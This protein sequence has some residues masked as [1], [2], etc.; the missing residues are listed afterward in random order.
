VLTLN[1]FELSVEDDN[2]FKQPTA[3]YSELD[4]SIVLIGDSE[5]ISFGEDVITVRFADLTVSGD[6]TLLL[7]AERIDVNGGY[8]YGD[9]IDLTFG[10][11]TVNGGM[12]DI[13]GS[14]HGIEIDYGNLTVNGGEIYI[15]AEDEGIDITGGDLTLNDGSIDI[16]ADDKGIDIGGN[17]TVNG[18][19]AEIFSDDDGIEVSE[20]LRITDGKIDVHSESIGIEVSGEVTIIGAEVEISALSEGLLAYGNVTLGGIFEISAELGGVVSFGDIL[21]GNV[22]FAIETDD[23]MYAIKAAAIT[24]EGEQ[25][26]VEI[27]QDSDAEGSYS[28]IDG[29][30]FGFGEYVDK[31]IL[32]HKDFT[33]R[34][35]YVYTGEEISI[36]LYSELSLGVDYILQLPDDAIKELGIYEVKIVGIGDYVGEISL[37]IGVHK[38][39]DLPCDESIDLNV[40]GYEDE[41]WTL[42]SFTP[43]YDGTYEFIFSCNSRSYVNL[44]DSDFAYNPLGSYVG[45]FKVTLELIGGVTYYF[46]VYSD[47]KDAL[48]TV[49]ARF[50]CNDHVG[51]E[52]TY[53]EQAVCDRCGNHYGDLLVC[54]HMCHADG[55]R[56][57]I[58][59]IFEFIYDFIGI[60]S[61]CK[62]GVDH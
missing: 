58:W 7:K 18:G 10:N 46:D 22:I 28:Y 6:G 41:I 30:Y 21:L 43:E 1:G 40:S 13:F 56:G 45:E 23:G 36:E 5:L 11:L 19:I 53:H 12:L 50:I 14:D 24:V 26:D 51:G 31:N 37:N 55:I 61:E 54:D 9:G 17:M 27:N 48:C 38:G 57:Y 15:D 52:A 35:D 49:S 29:S 34:Y 59:K 20:D 42:V 16:H 3:I 39:F 32:M 2:P 8:A 4:L 44:L 60:E 25:G 47:V 33:V 62:C